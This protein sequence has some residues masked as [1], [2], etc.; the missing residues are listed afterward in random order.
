MSDRTD[1]HRVRAVE[2]SA[3]RIRW[4]LTTMY[5]TSLLI[6]L[7]GSTAVVRLAMRDALEREFDQ[8]IRSSAELVSQFVRVEIGEYHTIDETLSH[9]ATELMFQD[10]SMHIHRPD[11][12]EFIVVGE[13][14]PRQR[15]ALAPPVRRVSLPL[16]E[17]LAPG[18]TIEV[19][20]SG[21]GMAAVEARLDRWIALGVPA[22]VVLA[23]LAGWWLTGRT[24]RPVG[25][26][27]DAASRIDAGSGGR[28]PV[29]DA[30]DE[31]GR[32]GTRFN[33]LLDRLDTAL[34][35]Q[36]RFIGDAAH[37]LRTP[38]AR[39]RSRV[40][41]AM[42]PSAPSEAGAPT[43]VDHVLP[44]VQDEIV[45]MS[46]LVDELLQLARADAGRDA[47]DD[48]L[49][50]LFLDDLVTDE[51]HRWHVEAQ[52]LGVTLRC[53][54]LQEAPIRGDDVQLGRLLGILVDNALRYGRPSGQV[55][56]RV[57]TQQRKAVLEVEDDGIGIDATDRVRL[58]ERFFRGTRARAHRADGSGLGLAIAQWIVRRHAGEIAITSGPGAVGTLVTVTLPLRASVT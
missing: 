17:D 36:R 4:R 52:R 10:R 57:S 33:A 34:E 56:V 19:E 2:R 12:R 14:R 58:F 22:L 55:D 37:E 1:P 6:L 15:P 50:Q 32:L 47:Q 43:E 30:H 41:V 26:M 38:L 45:R 8:S 25:L 13:T 24:L 11:G 16:A 31:L 7:L 42:L 40:E 46:R 48:A 20:A 29:A 3:P 54:V 53:S 18:W 39:L 44:A 5:A 51:L 23:A 9:V 49:H 27:A 35:Q 21:A 28:I